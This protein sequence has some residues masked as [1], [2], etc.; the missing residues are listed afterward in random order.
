M[1]YKLKVFYHDTDSGGVVY[2]SNYLN[3]FEEARTEFLAQK[4]INIKELI[5]NG[6]FFV[7]S[8][9]EVDYRAPAKFGD[10]LEITTEIKEV[11]GVRLNLTNKVL[12]NGQVLIAEAKTT[13]V[14]IGQ[15]F[16]PKPIPDD[17]REK[18]K[19]I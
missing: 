11:S 9:Q 17:I 10:S 16:R 4:G 15:N 12:K 8:R 6:A 1:A 2:H 5:Q 3:F 14:F 18:I 19:G 13:L 7:V